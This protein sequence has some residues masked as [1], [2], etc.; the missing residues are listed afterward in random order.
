MEMSQ[1]KNVEAS[2]KEAKMKIKKKR[3]EEPETLFADRSKD[4]QVRLM[5]LALKSEEAGLEAEGRAEGIPRCSDLIEALEEGKSGKSGG[6]KKKHV[7]HHGKKDNSLATLDV[8][9][10]SGQHGDETASGNIKTPSRGGGSRVST[11]NTI[12]K[13]S[14]QTSNSTSKKNKTTRGT[15]DSVVNGVDDIWD[16]DPSTQILE[17]N[18]PSRTGTRGITPV[19]VGTKKNPSPSRGATPGSRGG[20]SKGK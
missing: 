12:N 5:A 6:H 2:E 20:V 14:Q 16:F 1:K 11:A 8:N 3:K 10:S 4:E 13:P 18:S 17:D 19:G 15:S 7:L 9:A